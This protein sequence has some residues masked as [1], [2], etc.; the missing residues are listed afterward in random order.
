MK[1]IISLILTAVL[2]SGLLVVGTPLSAAAA[3]ELVVEDML[4]AADAYVQKKLNDVTGEG[5]LAAVQTAAPTSWDTICGPATT[6][7]AA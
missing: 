5:L 4:A 3:D 7:H 6:G 1:R 2:L